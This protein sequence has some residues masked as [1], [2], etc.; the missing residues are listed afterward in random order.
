VQA[1][2]VGELKAALALGH[3]E[4]SALCA[5]LVSQRREILRGRV[6]AAGVLSDDVSVD[7]DILL[8]NSKAISD[9]RSLEI[10]SGSITYCDG[11]E[12]IIGMARKVLAGYELISA[13][14]KEQI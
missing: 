8:E 13:K 2:A 12:Q 6:M 9:I 7:V 4:Y 10:P 14:Q 1:K 5:D 3:Q 11:A